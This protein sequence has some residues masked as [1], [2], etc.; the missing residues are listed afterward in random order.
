MAPAAGAVHA[1]PT[2]DPTGHQQSQT[3]TAD[4]TFPTPL[5]LSGVLDAY[6][7]FDL[8]PTIG[9]EFPKVNLVEFLSAPNSDEL[10]R[11]VAITSSLTAL[12]SSPP[13]LLLLQSPC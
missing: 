13:R 9:R 1:N 12:A 7:H 5:K 11:D 6:E 8:T 4:P 3:A 10:L 2:F